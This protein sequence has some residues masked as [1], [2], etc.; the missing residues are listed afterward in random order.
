MRH[1]LHIISLLFFCACSSQSTVDTSSAQVDL[2]ASRNV[3]L[4]SN[5]TVDMTAEIVLISD[6]ATQADRYRFDV[7][8][9]SSLNI[10]SFALTLTPGRY[11]IGAVC[12][13]R[14]YYQRLTGLI[15]LEQLQNGIWWAR[16]STATGSTAL[17]PVTVIDVQLSAG[18]T[19]SPVNLHA[20]SSKECEVIYGMQTIDGA[21]LNMMPAEFR[22]K[23]SKKIRLLN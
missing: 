3:T 21:P 15:R 12:T 23:Y 13:G 9:R 11:Q 6:L 10:E 18:D 17:L 2:A 20:V 22:K 1:I 16:F 4:S 19:L 7:Q 14:N 5:Q 8:Y